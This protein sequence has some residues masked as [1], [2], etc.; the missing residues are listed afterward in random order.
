[1]DVTYVH[2]FE[3][4]VNESLKMNAYI[5]NPKE[6]LS[7]TKNLNHTITLMKHF[8]FYLIALTVC[9][10]FASCSDEFVELPY[11]YEIDWRGYRL[12]IPL[13]TVIYIENQAEFDQLFADEETKPEASVPFSEGV[14]AIVKGEVGFGTSDPQK[15]L[16][17]SGNRYLLSIRIFWP[18]AATTEITTWYAAYV[19]PIEYVGKVDLDIEYI[20]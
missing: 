8:L 10:P 4:Y 19:I 15:S 6:N 3:T 16:T 13:D 1:M 12:D 18:E 14:L 5:C 7:K 17:L 11:A 2:L 9:L 20:K